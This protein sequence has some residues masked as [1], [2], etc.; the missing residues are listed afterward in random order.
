M[1][2]RWHLL[3]VNKPQQ[4]SLWMLLYNFH[5][6]FL[7]QQMEQANEFDTDRLLLERHALVMNHLDHCLAIMD[8]VKESEGKY[9]KMAI[10]DADS[11]DLIYKAADSYDSQNTVLSSEDVKYLSKEIKKLRELIFESNKYAYTREE[12][13]KGGIK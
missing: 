2:E 6:L 8:A 13:T 3:V 9:N 11:M 10:L 1:E 5:G 12:L 7:L 4:K